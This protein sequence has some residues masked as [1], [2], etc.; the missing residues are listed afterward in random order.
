MLWQWL[1]LYLYLDGFIAD[2]EYLKSNSLQHCFNLNKKQIGRNCR[3]GITDQ[4]IIILS[5]SIHCFWSHFKTSSFRFY[6]KHYIDVIT[7]AT[8]HMATYIGLG[9][10]SLFNLSEPLP[11]LILIEKTLLYLN[12]K[13]I[14]LLQSFKFASNVFLKPCM[15]S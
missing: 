2:M 14:D 7:V 6:S 12:Q 15:P 11:L 4:I 13:R 10:K 1:Q 3:I 5:P 8:I 9:I